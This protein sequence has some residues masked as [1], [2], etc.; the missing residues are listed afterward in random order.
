MPTE[1]TDDW[2]QTWHS[3]QGTLG[4]KWAFHVLHVLASDRCS[5]SELENEIDGISATML[6]R[7]LSDLRERGFIEKSTVPRTPPRSFYQLT[8]A[9]E[10][11]ATFLSEMERVAT[12]TETRDGVRLVF[13]TQSSRER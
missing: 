10:R 2:Q 4:N 3:L 13:D 7:R 8:T 6:S 1:T 9:G 5:F 11:V 12:T